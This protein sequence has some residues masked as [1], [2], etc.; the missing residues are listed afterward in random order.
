MLMADIAGEAGEPA[1]ASN[2]C[3][4]VEELWLLMLTADNA[5]EA[6]EPAEAETRP[7]GLMINV[8]RLT[9]GMGVSN[10]CPGDEE[11]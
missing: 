8:E 1:G 5:G 9:S 2:V 7:P 4:R 10:V 11:L 3:P 6:G